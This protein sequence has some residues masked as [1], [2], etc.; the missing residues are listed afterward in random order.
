[1][2]GHRTKHAVEKMCEVFKVSRSGY[3]DWLYRKPSNRSIE[4]IQLKSE[5]NLIYQASK[6]RYGSLKITNKLTQL[7]WVVSRPRVARMMRSE[8]IRSIINKKYRCVT[9]ESNHSISI[10]E[11]LLSRDFRAIRSGQKWVSDITYIPT[12]QGWL[13]LTIVLDLFDR[14]IVGWA[15]STNMTAKD[16][17]VAAWR[18]AVKTDQLREYCFIQ[19]EVS[20]MRAM[21]LDKY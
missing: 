6:K 9:T 4:T 10:S 12:K 3:Y 15:L 7:G 13:Y 5:I 16:T 1:M 18:M 21:N 17:V 2:K 20:N 8:G 19:T 14:K 11:N